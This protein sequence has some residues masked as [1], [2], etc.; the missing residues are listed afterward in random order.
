MSQ[1]TPPPPIVQAA[2]V[3][4]PEDVDLNDLGEFPVSGRV[5]GP[6][7][8]PVAGATVYLRGYGVSVPAR[9]GTTDAEGRFTFT[10]KRELG[11]KITQTAP[12]KYAG[13]PFPTSPKSGTSS[14]ASSQSRPGS[15]SVS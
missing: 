9:K 5:I 4:P 11:L 8:K 7:A 6:D 12:N 13:G 2:V 1:K 15:A 10:S 14:H 3:A